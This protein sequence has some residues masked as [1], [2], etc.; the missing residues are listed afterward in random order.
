MING[1]IKIFTKVE[2]GNRRRKII[3]W[4]VK[5]FSKREKSEGFGQIVYSEIKVLA[6]NKVGD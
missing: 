3:H 6:K 4:L 5:K 1:L 2:V